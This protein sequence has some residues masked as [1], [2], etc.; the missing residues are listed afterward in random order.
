MIIEKKDFLAGMDGDTNHRELLNS[1]MLNLMNGRMG[2]TEYGRM[3]RIEN[4]P[5]TTL[6]QQAVYP[7][8]GT[9]QVIGSCV[10]PATERLVYFVWNSFADH[11][12]YCFDFNTRTTYAI[13]YDSQ[14]TDGLNFSKNSRIDRN[15]HVTNGMVYW[16]ENENNQPRKLNIDSGIKANHASYDTDEIPYEFPL[17]N[18][19]FTIIK[20]PPP[21]SP[22]IQKDTDATFEN[23]FIA[24]DS[25]MFAFL[26]DW[27]DNERTVLGTYSPASRLNKV[28]DTENFI[29][30]TMDTLERI[31]SSVR[32]VSLVVRI[33]DGTFGGGNIG[34]IIKTWDK[35]IESEENDIIA[36]NSGAQE[37][38]FDFYNNITGESI[39]KENILKPFDSVPI[40]SKTLAQ[41]RQRN[42]LGNNTEGYDSPQSTSL[43][44]SATNVNI[45]GSFLN[46]TLISIFTRNGR[47]QPETFAYSGWFVYLTEV[48]PV[49][50]YLVNGTNTLREDTSFIGGAVYGN[51]GDVPLPNPA[52]YTTIAFSG[53]TFK[54]ASLSDVANNTR[55]A[56]TFRWDGPYTTFTAYPSSITGLSTQT[57]DVFKTRSQ[58]KFGVVFY[59][60]A[61]RKC[62]VVTNDGLI[63]EIAPRDYAFSSATSGIVWTL[64]NT[65]A[66]TEIPD[67][68]YYYTPVRTLN[69][70]TRFF[71]DSF[72]NAAKYA[73]RNT[74]GGYEYSSNTF[75][76]GSVGIALDTTALIQSGLG[77]TFT[78]GDIA[79]LTL[80]NATQYELPVIAQ[81]GNYIIVKADNIGDLTTR[82]IVYEI[83]TPYQ[84]SEQEP[85]YEV[86]QMY[87]IL[88][89]GTISR[90]YE[91]LTDIFVPDAYVLTRNYGANTYFAEAMCPNDLFYQR[92]DNDGGKVNFVTKLGQ[93]A[94]T[95][96]FRFSNTFVPGT[97]TNGLSTF[98]ALNQDN[99]S[100]DSGEI[101]KLILTDKVQDEGTVMLAICRNETNSIY[102]GE[103]QISDATGATQFFARA[104]GVVGTI[105]SLKG[106]FGTVNPETVFEYLGLVF[107]LDALNGVV[108]QYSQSGLE[109]VSRYGQN[110]FFQ[111]YCKNY[112]QASTG[113]LDNINGF[114]HIP[115]CIDPFHKEILFTLPA[116]IYENYANTLPSY[117]SV[118]DYA[119]SIIDRFDIY[120][121][122][123]KTMAY[124]FLENKWGSNFEYGSEWME[125]FQDTMV[126]FK[127]GYLYIHNDDTTNW[128]TFYGTQRPKRICVAAN[129]NPSALKNLYNIAIEGNEIP[130]FTVAMTTYPNE[131]ITDLSDDDYTNQEGTAYAYFF[132]DRLSPNATGTADERLYTGDVL[133]D[134]AIFVMVEFP[135]YES[136]GYTNFIDIGYDIARGQ[137]QI[138][139]S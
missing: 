74:D 8:Y 70:R 56:D 105:N 37:L 79:V 13:I 85:F 33:G 44:L 48:L 26:Y 73:T 1:A 12:I 89:P 127:D 6:I 103:Q 17:D 114:H 25:F 52:A 124:C 101:N 68:A 133:K 136:L 90:T 28:D 106:S 104:G 108:V 99:V 59:D 9:Q 32:M 123:G 45:G 113:N 130:E 77:Y 43:A 46:K 36:Q 34:K 80:D 4:I 128:N 131:Q 125:Y 110:R 86:G 137:K 84:T 20:P 39:P 41:A 121:E 63:F 54:G 60:F 64:S 126:G 100:E 97:S 24:N 139:T 119:S 102:L 65:N 5:G 23:N 35:D 75:V 19:Y 116:L 109:P 15:C 107:W 21:L 10:D 69:L 94:K 72:T 55:P 120:D 7:P 3:K 51:G 83:Y 95:N 62:G 96:F 134:F 18:R 16:C 93:V 49:G 29:T 61:M 50:Y 40:Y 11:G 38:T 14:T 132:N 27:Y 88:D 138:I 135:N 30:V 58:Y 112:L 2:V 71:I 122:L 53:L 98:E 82:R 115:S 42:F 92:W 91:T 22:N 117:S 87:R 57:Y 129:A 47:S 111:R 76:T 118:P 66:L 31:P 81:D 67:W 78:Q